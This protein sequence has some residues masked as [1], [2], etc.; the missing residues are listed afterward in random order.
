MN[1]HTE[2]LSLKAVSLK[3][4][5]SGLDFLQTMSPVPVQSWDA[6]AHQEGES[7]VVHLDLSKELGKLHVQQ[8]AF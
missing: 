1:F 3:Q 6:K 7:R 4:L 8:L 2:R 5:I